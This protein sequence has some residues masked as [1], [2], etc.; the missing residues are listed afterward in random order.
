[1]EFLKHVL[2]L[3]KGSKK[4]SKGTYL[5]FKTNENENIIYPNLWDGAKLFKREFYSSK[6][7]I[8]TEEKSQISNLILYLRD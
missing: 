2:D 4:K 7:Y 3:P 5:C 8:K 1:M 6:T